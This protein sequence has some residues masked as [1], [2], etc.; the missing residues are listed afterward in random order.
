MPRQSIP[1][2]ATRV[3]GKPSRIEPRPDAPDDVRAI[4]RD[5]VASVA[6]DHFTTADRP[7][8]ESYS[9][10]IALSRL[11][12]A[13]LE[14][15]G[16]VVNGKTSAWVVIQEKAHRSQVALSARLRLCP[17]SRFDRTKAGKT[18]RDSR[19]P[20]IDWSAS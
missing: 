13:E 3:D 20:S 1:A 10:A 5:L 19:V 11:A 12:Y 16:P 7:L 8:L 4:F 17:Q 18:A 14:K 2:Q 6:S 15:S 9:E